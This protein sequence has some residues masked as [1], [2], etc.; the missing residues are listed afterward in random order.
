MAVFLSVLVS[1]CVSVSLSHVAVLLSVF[2]SF[3]SFLLLPPPILL[4]APVI[5]RQNGNSPAIHCCAAPT[6]PPSNPQYP[7]G[8]RIWDSQGGQGGGPS[9]DPME[10]VPRVQRRVTLYVLFNVS[11]SFPICNTELRKDNQGLFSAGYFGGFQTQIP[12][13]GWDEPSP[14]PTLSAL[15][16]PNLVW[17]SSFVGGNYCDWCCACP[18]RLL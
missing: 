6:R 16:V 9:G 7:L 3:S 1:L 11:L 13:P 18:L 14:I 4:A 12:S 15:C 8:L 17:W 2:V 10:K 5:N